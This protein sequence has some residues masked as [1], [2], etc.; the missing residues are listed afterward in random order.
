MTNWAVQLTSIVSLC[1]QGSLHEFSLRSGPRIFGAVI[2]DFRPKMSP[3]KCD[4]GLFSLISRRARVG[5]SNCS[6][7]HM[8]HCARF[9]A[10]SFQVPYFAVVEEMYDF[11]NLHPLL[12]GPARVANERKFR[13]TNLP[14]PHYQHGQ[15]TI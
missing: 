15:I 5:F 2:M 8:H 12:A 13:P 6:D 4:F 9:S 11:N 7:L 1:F 3:K 14:V 10:G